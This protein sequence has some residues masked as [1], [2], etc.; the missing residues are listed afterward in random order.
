M[1]QSRVQTITSAMKI[2]VKKVSTVFRDGCSRDVQTPPWGD[3]STS[4]P[5]G[6]HHGPGT[7]SAD[8]VVEIQRTAAARPRR[9]EWGFLGALWNRRGRVTSVI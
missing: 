8:Y 1:N 7:V 9:E 6:R 4:K 3:A 2:R 5:L